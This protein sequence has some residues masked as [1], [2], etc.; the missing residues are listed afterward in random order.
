MELKIGSWFA[1]L[2][3]VI[4]LLERGNFMIEW[5]ERYTVNVSYWSGV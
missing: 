3:V 4:G 2:D 5:F 1:L